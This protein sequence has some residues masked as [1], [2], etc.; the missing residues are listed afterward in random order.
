VDG[1]TELLIT[2]RGQFRGDLDMML[3]LAIIGS[4]TLPSRRHPV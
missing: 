1:F 3:V 2:L 4:R